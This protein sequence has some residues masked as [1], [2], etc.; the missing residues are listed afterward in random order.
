ML[1]FPNQFWIVLWNLFWSLSDWEVC[2]RGRRGKQQQIDRFFA[3]SARQ[4][5]NEATAQL[6]ERAESDIFLVVDFELS[7]WLSAHFTTE[8]IHGSDLDIIF[9]L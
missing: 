1:F 5:C 4:A 8:S 7:I 9:V 6:F 2:P 3:W